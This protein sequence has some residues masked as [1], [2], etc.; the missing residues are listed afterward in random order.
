MENTIGGYI[1]MAK[2]DSR[3]ME[4][5]S[6]I[7][8][9]RKLLKDA[10]K[11]S[12]ETNCSI[13]LDGTRYNLHAA[14]KSD[15]IFLLCKLHTL[16][17]AAQFYAYSDE[18]MISGYPA[19]IWINDIRSRLKSMDHNREMKKLAFLESK[20]NALL[21]DDKKTELEIDNI[22]SMLKD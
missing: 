18:L 4:L 10:P 12:P 13:E 1:H 21:S 17:Q 5:K 11:F 22:A 20:L 19:K 6:Q 2:N 14:D 3:I 8:T 9:K 16:Q 7:E 15:L